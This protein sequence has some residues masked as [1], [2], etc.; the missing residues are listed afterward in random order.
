M[1]RVKLKFV[2][3]TVA[4]DPALTEKLKEDLTRY[5]YLS[6][7]LPAI[8]HIILALAPKDDTLYGFIHWKRQMR[9]NAVARILGEEADLLP[10]PRQH[11]RRELDEF[12]RRHYPEPFTFE[13]GSESTH[14]HFPPSMP[15][16]W[17]KELRTKHSAASRSLKRAAFLDR[18]DSS[19]CKTAE[20][21]AN[22]IN[23]GS[24]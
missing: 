7:Y 18:I 11:L 15:E 12:T 4:L 21:I 20:Q 9:Y 22:K 13:H 14:R 10:V 2:F 6:M 5:R 3:F 8:K 19:N 24:V 16:D 1:E 17:Q 23:E